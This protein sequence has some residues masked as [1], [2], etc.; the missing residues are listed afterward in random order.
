LIAAWIPVA[1][2]FGGGLALARPRLLAFATTAAVA[3]AGIGVT[4]KVEQTPALQRTDWRAVS[5]LLGPPGLAREV[6]VNPAYNAAALEFYGQNLGAMPVGARLQELDLI[7]VGGSLSQAPP[8]GFVATM[9]RSVSGVIVLRFRALRPFTVTQAAIASAGQPLLFEFSRAGTR[10]IT[11]F[12][13][14]LAT[15]AHALSDVSGNRSARAILAAAPAAANALAVVPEEI[16]RTGA[17]LFSRLR[18]VA[19]LAAAVAA[20]PRSGTESALRQA[21]GEL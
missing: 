16:P 13:A 21:L 11:R 14:D 6:I 9:R 19:S 8:P 4:S 1:I 18:Q 15:W 5:R 7:V 12:D 2:A 3:A 20:H 17:Q 10:W